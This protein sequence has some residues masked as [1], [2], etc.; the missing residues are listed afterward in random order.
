MNGNY[1]IL[2]NSEALSQECLATVYSV[3]VGLTVVQVQT[4]RRKTGRIWQGRLK[5]LTQAQEMLMSHRRSNQSN[6]R[7]PDL[8]S[9]ANP[10]WKDYTLQVALIG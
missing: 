8:K 6:N 5:D 9:R 2:K 10:A 4:V 3:G 1:S 7:L